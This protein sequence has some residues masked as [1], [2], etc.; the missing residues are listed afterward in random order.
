MAL[1][2][3]G[4]PDDWQSKL[5]HYTSALMI[6]R[7]RAVGL[8]EDYSEGVVRVLIARSPPLQAP[9]ALILRTFWQAP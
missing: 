3:I 2:R 9:K 4:I 1:G 5:A 6:A 8:S 7:H